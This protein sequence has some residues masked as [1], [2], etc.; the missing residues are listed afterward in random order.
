MDMDSPAHQLSSRKHLRSSDDESSDWSSDI[1]GQFDD[2]E[3]A[4]ADDHRSPP[5]KLTKRRRSND[6]PL[7]EE[8]ADY[9]SHD[10]RTHRGEN[11]SRSV[12]G[13]GSGYKASPRASPRG[14]LASLRARHPR[15]RTS[16]FIEATMSDSVSEKPPSI[17]FQEQENKNAGMQHRSSGIFRFGKA[18]ASAFNPFGGWGRNSEEAPNKSPQKDVI[19]QAEQAYAE[20][21][22]AGYKGT[23]KGHYTE[24]LGVNAALADQT[25]RSIQQK[26]EHGSPV[27]EPYRHP[28]D[29]VDR[30]APSRSESSA[31]KRSSLQDL[32]LPKSFFKSHGSPS[33]PSAVYCDRKSDEYESTGLRKQP[34][35]REL[36]RQT[37][38]LKKVSNLEDKLQRARREL[39]DL[40]GNEERITAP[41][42]QPKTLNT[43]MDPASFPKKF[44]PGALPTL[45]SER[46]LDQKAAENETA[47]PAVTNLTA[48]PS[49][50]DRETFFFEES[51]LPHTPAKAQTTKRHLK[52]TQ[53]SSMGKDRSSRKR[54]SSIPEPIH[55]GN[56]PQPS[57]TKGLDNHERDPELEVLIDSGLLS[58]PG[59]AKWPKSEAGESPGSA[60][61]KQ[62]IDHIA[63]STE[64]EEQE[65]G[66]ISSATRNIK[67]SPYVQLRKVPGSSCSP[68]SKPNPPLRMRNSQTS[69]RPESSPAAVSDGDSR[70]NIWSTPLSALPNDSYREAFYH[71]PQRQLNPDRSP[72][73]PTRSKTGPSRRRSGYLGDDDIPPV[74]PLPE[75]LRLSAAKVNVNVNRSPKKRPLS[76]PMLSS[77]SA[78][79]PESVIS[80][81]EDYQWP[82][83]IF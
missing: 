23:N 21:K 77:S 29:Q 1:S 41:T 11:G 45:P 43:E 2:A 70:S 35:R 51:R 68:S 12:S 78:S 9:G 18:I 65:A 44:V 32:R 66:R 6:W 28:I 38:L 52:G 25:W 47:G 46:L 13:N 22:K 14:S 83:D 15:G 5:A 50:D 16:R 30:C 69:T 3:E 63:L 56:S 55:S 59:K 19:H 27:K 61:R 74:P 62:A 17:Y 76:A 73:T 80:G 7:P 24:G 4:Q 58:P 10:R 75:E 37:K 8:A 60:K 67:R 79:G 53:P 42:V 33:A 82:E 54:K 81:L 31:S 39:R 48:L 71:H 57:S 40:T 49:V 64:H 20:L 34:S 26:M 72:R 36:S